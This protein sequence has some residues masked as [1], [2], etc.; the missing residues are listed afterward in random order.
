MNVIKLLDVVIVVNVAHVTHLAICVNNL[1]LKNEC[2]MLHIFIN[3]AHVTLYLYM[4]I[5]CDN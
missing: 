4:I 1:Y 2:L 5:I 3:V